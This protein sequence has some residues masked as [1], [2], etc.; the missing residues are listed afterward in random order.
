MRYIFKGLKH[1]FP[2]K[3]QN[4]MRITIHAHGEQEAHKKAQKEAERWHMELIPNEQHDSLIW[5]QIE[6]KP[7]K[8]KPKNKHP[9]K[10]PELNKHELNG[11]VKQIETIYRT[12][13]SGWNYSRLGS[14]SAWEVRKIIWKHKIGFICKY[15]LVDF[16]GRYCCPEHSNYYRTINMSM[17]GSQS[18][19]GYRHGN[20]IDH[21]KPISMGGLEFD[22]DNLQWMDL[23]ENIRKG[24]A[25]RFRA[26]QRAQLKVQIQT[27]FLQAQ[28]LYKAIGFGQSNIKRY[29]EKRI[30]KR[31]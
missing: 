29:V 26:E 8:P 7:R 25:N 10:P 17:Y 16:R 14:I 11:L 9:A 1:G 22:R 5:E 2:N 19:W 30:K 15:C 27:A 21:I 24:G 6:V 20:S 13:K 28:A 12:T 18:P 31:D 23:S 3:P 4:Y